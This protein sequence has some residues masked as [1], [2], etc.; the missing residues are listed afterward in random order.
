MIVS[1]S[2]LEASALPDMVTTKQII[3]QV[4]LEFS[5]FQT[6]NCNIAKWRSMKLY[7]NLVQASKNLNLPF[8]NV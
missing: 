2:S 3:P 6:N 7:G 4:S 1:D 5:E 8:E